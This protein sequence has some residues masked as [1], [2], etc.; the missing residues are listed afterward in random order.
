MSDF[1]SNNVIQN[2]RINTYIYV[3]KNEYSR[4]DDTH[5]EIIHNVSS[6][7]DEYLTFLKVLLENIHEILS[8]EEKNLD[9]VIYTNNIYFKYIINE[10]FVKWSKKDFKFDGKSR[11]Y[12]LEY[13]EL[14]KIINTNNLIITVEHVY[15]KNN[16][17]FNKLIN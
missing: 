4:F 8:L 7:N 17:S 13:T 10:W 9:L 16:A 14:K 2:K 3:Q 6:E 15:G 12:F 11:P 5:P 1:F